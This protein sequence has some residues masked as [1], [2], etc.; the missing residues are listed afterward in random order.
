LD[1]LQTAYDNLEE[2]LANTRQIL[3]DYEK[4]TKSLRADAMRSN[5]SSHTSVQIAEKEVKLLRDE[6]KLLR[7]NNEKL[8]A[9]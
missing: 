8:E 7:S 6:V 5:E 4:S 1:K 2:E 9:R 3:K